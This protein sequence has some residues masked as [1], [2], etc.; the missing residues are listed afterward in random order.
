MSKILKQ[1]IKTE[2]KLGRTIYSESGKD[3]KNNF[4]FSPSKFND[5][6]KS[7]RITNKQ[8]DEVK[9]LIEAIKPLNLKYT[10]LSPKMPRST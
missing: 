3:S 1:L 10:P 8:N 2:K 4:T 9:N 7:G 6:H 5:N